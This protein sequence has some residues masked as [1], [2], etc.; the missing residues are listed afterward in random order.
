[1]RF[2]DVLVEHIMRTSPHAGALLDDIVGRLRAYDVE[3]R[4]DLLPTLRAYVAANLNVSRTA[5]VLHV[6]ANTV[7]YRL[8]RI[9]ELVQRDPMKA[10][11]LVVLMIALKAD[12]LE[13]GAS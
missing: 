1:M 12:E 10:D 2:D 7:A 4:T 9:A 11:D 6:H 8:R 5:T 13:A 3:R